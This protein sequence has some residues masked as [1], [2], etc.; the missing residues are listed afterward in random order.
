L[1]VDASTDAMTASFEADEECVKGP[2]KGA[3]GQIAPPNPRAAV[4]VR[5]ELPP[6]VLGVA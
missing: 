3:A 6:G 5:R 4:V 2:A 1:T